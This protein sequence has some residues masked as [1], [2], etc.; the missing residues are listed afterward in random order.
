M[1]NDKTTKF[2]NPDYIPFDENVALY[3]AYSDP[4]VNDIYLSPWTF[5][6]WKDETMSWKKTC[7]LG[8]VLAPCL[9]AVISGPD[10]VTFLKKYFVNGFEK[11]RVGSGRH[12]II[13]NNDGQIIGDGVMLRTD[14]QRFETFFISPAVDFCASKEQGK[15]DFTF[16][17]DSGK[18]FM[19]Q[20]GGPRSLEIV[21]NACEEDLHDLK[22][23]KFRTATIAGHKVRI[24]R[25]GMAGTLSYEVHGHME[26]AQDVY[27]KLYEVGKPYGIRRLGWQAYNYCN[28]TENG[29]PQ[30][31]YHYAYPWH[32]DKEFCDWMGVP[33]EPAQVIK[34]SLKPE[35]QDLVYVTP[36]DNGWGSRVKFDHDFQGRAALEK[37]YEEQ[38][39]TTVTLEWNDEDVIDLFASLFRDVTYDTPDL[40][41]YETVTSSDP[42][43]ADEVRDAEGNLVGISTGRVYT[44]Y[45]KKMISLCTLKK[46]YATEGTELYITWGEIGHPQKKIR[47]KVARL[48]YFNVDRNNS[49]D[50]EQVPHYKK[51]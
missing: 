4:S 21:E 37:A 12:G 23:M 44:Y 14:E 39:R 11:F 1:P 46:E 15:L 36:Y 50:V 8:A 16:E 3:R 49:F 35:D 38:P 45:Y 6:G 13:C 51:Q 17:N 41:Y 19:F 28:H 31:Y 47:A 22:F 29:F 30:F 34:G 24:L 10:S 18:V 27:T 48:P 5:T 9:H 33:Q 25:M 26:D 7:Y 43:N 40:P 2:V 20:L 32:K 42:L